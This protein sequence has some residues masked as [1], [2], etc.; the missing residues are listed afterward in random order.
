MKVADGDDEAV[1]LVGSIEKWMSFASPG[2][3]ISKQGY[4]PI[5]KK[6]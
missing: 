4:P 6:V 5:V 1:E 3:T 2:M